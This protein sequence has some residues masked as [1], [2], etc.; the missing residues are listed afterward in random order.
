M[1]AFVVKHMV[2][3]RG[4]DIPVILTKVCQRPYSYTD[5]EEMTTC[6]MGCDIYV[7]ESLFSEVLNQTIYKLAYRY[8]TGNFEPSDDKDFD[9]KLMESITE[10]FDGYYFEKPVK[11]SSAPDLSKF[12]YWLREQKK[13]GMKEIPHEFV[14][15]LKS[16]SEDLSFGAKSF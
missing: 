12:I 11:L 2:E 7:I 6:A 3:D 1:T 9:F 16:F 8:K 5:K 14:S 13:T 4:Y 15:D 10:P